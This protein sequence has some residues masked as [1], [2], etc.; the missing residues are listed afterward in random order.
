LALTAVPDDATTDPAKVRFLGMSTELEKPPQYGDTQKFVVLAR[1][2]GE[3][4]DEQQGGMVRYRKM[5]VLEVEPGEIVAAPTDPQLAIDDDLFA[6]G[7]ADAPD[8]DR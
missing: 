6:M 5:R 3:G 4:F 8:G 7:A 1:C 2:I